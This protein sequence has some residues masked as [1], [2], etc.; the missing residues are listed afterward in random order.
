MFEIAGEDNVFYPA[1]TKLKGSTIIVYSNQ[2]KQ[3][4]KVRFA[5]GNALQSNVFNEAGLPASSFA[6][7]K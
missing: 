3:P 7:E 1:K 6:T 5:W 4:Q 2:V